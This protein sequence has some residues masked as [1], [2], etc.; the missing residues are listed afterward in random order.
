MYQ[1]KGFDLHTIARDNARRISVRLFRAFCPTKTKNSQT[2][3]R[4]NMDSGR[5]V[6]EAAS[7]IYPQVISAIETEVYT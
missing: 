3:S 1:E 7:E 6:K 4:M 5:L 2:Q